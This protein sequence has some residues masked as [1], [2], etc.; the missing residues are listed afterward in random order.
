MMILPMFLPSGGMGSPG[1]PNWKRIAVLACGYVAWGVALWLTY[2]PHGDEFRGALVG[3]GWLWSVAAIFWT[4]IA[5]LL[6]VAGL[7]SVFV[8]AFDE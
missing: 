4:A 2:T 3:Q 7:V 6:V 5:V 8:W 1:T